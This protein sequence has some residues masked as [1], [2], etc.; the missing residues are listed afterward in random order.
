MILLFLLKRKDLYL[1]SVIL[2]ASEH[3]RAGRKGDH[4]K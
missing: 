4:T 2:M 1:I 3:L